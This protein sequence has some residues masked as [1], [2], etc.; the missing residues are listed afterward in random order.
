MPPPANQRLQSAKSC[1]RVGRLVDQVDPVA[2]DLMPFPLILPDARLWAGVFG[3]SVRICF[4]TESQHSTGGA[5]VVEE[6]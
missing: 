2:L 4:V 1:G 5:L 3:G 6:V